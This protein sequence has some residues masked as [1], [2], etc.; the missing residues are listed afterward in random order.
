MATYRVHG[1]C[2]PSMLARAPERDILPPSEIAER[3]GSA[4]ASMSEDAGTMET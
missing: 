2:M 1:C 4:C 3:A